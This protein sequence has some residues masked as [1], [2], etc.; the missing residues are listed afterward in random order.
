MLQAEGRGFEPRWAC[1]RR[2]S[3]PKTAF[4]AL[5][6]PVAWRGVWRC[7]SMGFD[8]PV[9]LACCG[10]FVPFWNLW[11]TSGTPEP[12]SARAA[13]CDIYVAPPARRPGGRLHPQHQSPARHHM[14]LRSRRRRP[15]GVTGP[16]QDSHGPT[17]APGAI[18]GW[19]KPPPRLCLFQRAWRRTR[20]GPG[21][22][23]Q[24]H[25]TPGGRA[26]TAGSCAPRVGHRLYGKNCHEKPS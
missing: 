18:A 11:H 7:G 19:G 6:L 4:F 21:D 9:V 24:D 14:G 1:A 22:K 15:V 8:T 12:A 2:F 3:S 20:C 5:L 16:Y 13:A 25:R 17:I 10:Q 26:A 23:T